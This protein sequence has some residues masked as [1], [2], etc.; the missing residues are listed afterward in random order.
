MSKGKNVTVYTDSKYVHGI[1]HDFARTWKQRNFKTADGKQISHSNLVAELIEATQMSKQLAVV[2][3]AGHVSGDDKTAVGNRFADEVA[4]DAAA[5]GIQSPYVS[6]NTQ[7]SYM[8]SHITNLAD[9][10]IKFLQSQ[11]STG[12][13]EHWAANECKPGKDGIIRDRQNRIALPKLALMP[14]I[15]HY[16]GISHVSKNKVIETINK[17]YCIAK[18]RSS[19]GLILDSCLTCKNKSTPCDQT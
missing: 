3:V 2:K 1:T 11:P 12:D 17:L 8:M 19:V 15:R 6:C 14:L 18:V 9:I 7:M 13:V 10:D 4:K 5:Q 16:H